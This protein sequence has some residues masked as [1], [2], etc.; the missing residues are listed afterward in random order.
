MCFRPPTTLGPAALTCS[1]PWGVGLAVA[2]WLG[3]RAAIAARAAV[4]TSMVLV[5]V[6]FAV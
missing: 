4:A 1:L 3:R 5:A 6:M 2:G